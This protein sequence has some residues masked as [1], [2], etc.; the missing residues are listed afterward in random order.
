M[1]DAKCITIVLAHL[2]CK[3]ASAAR[4]MRSLCRALFILDVLYCVLSLFEDRLPG[5]KM[6][7][8]VERETALIDKDGRGVDPRAYLPRDAHV[9]DFAQ[10]AEV[11]LF[12]C[13]K[14]PSRAPFSLEDR[15]RGVRHTIT[16]SAKGCVLD[17]R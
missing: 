12:I 9:V 2:G 1:G 7:E 4:A 15:T 16:L 10:A 3:T 13:G 11:A 6:F 5:W 17:A 8:A 14:E